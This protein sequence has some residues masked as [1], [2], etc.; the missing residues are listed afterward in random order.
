[1]MVFHDVGSVEGGWMW[2]S[3]MLAM[4]RIQCAFSHESGSKFINF[5]ILD[6]HQLFA[7]R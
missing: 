2:T 6:V 5:E 3:P 4:S 1:M 7:V